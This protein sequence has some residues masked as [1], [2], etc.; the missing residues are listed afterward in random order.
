MQDICWDD[1]SRKTEYIK[2][3]ECLLPMLVPGAWANQSKHK[4]G[5]C[6]QDFICPNAYHQGYPMKNHILVCEKHKNENQNQDTLKHYKSRCIL[7]QPIPTYAKEINLSLHTESDDK[8]TD[9][10]F[11][12]QNILV[13]EDV[14]NISYDTGCS[15]FISRHDA[16]KLLKS[17][18]TQVYNVPILTNGVGNQESEY[19]PSIFLS[20][21]EKMQQWQDFV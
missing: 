10:I 1:T 6:Q 18:A 19:T 11:M 2:V 9:A 15:D 8:N 5:L 16:V 17:R 3:Q 12:F 7:R 13:D 4:E 14:Y 21:M 20:Q